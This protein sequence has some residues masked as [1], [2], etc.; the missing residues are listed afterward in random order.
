MRQAC[1]QCSNEEVFESVRQKRKPG[2]GASNLFW[3]LIGE[4][5]ETATTY[6]AVA[7][8]AAPSPYIPDVDAQLIG[9]RVITGRQTA[10]SL[11]NNYQI[12]LTCTTF[13]PNTIHVGAVG[14]GLQTAPAQ[15][16]VTV[17]FQV[18]QPVKAGVPVTIEGRNTYANGVTP[19]NLIFGLFSC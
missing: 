5:V 1:F 8:A 6:G 18:N 7:G 13:Q 16:P 12:R 9:I 10:S 14:S 2:P 11:T 4:M 15:E 3:R 17:D 19:D